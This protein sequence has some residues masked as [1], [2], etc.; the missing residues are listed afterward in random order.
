MAQKKE[1]INHA[2]RAHAL[3]SASGA[4]RWMACTPSVRIEE[5]YGHGDDE[6]SIFAKEGT[7]AHELSELKLIEVA[8]LLNPIDEDPH[9]D[10]LADVRAHELYAYEMEE[11]T[12]TY[13]DTIM[14]QMSELGSEAKLLIEERVD[15]SKYAPE[16]F[17]TGDALI[18]SPKVLVIGDLKYGKGV[19]VDATD[20]S[21]L[22]L[23]ALGALSRYH[24]DYPEIETVRLI[25][26]QPRLDHIDKYELSVKDLLK[27]GEEVVKVKASE[28]MAGTGDFKAG[29]HCRWC[30][31]APRC[32][33]LRDFSIEA[34]KADF[35]LDPEDVNSAGLTDDEMVQIFKDMSVIELWINKVQ[36]YMHKEAL[37]GKHWKGLKLVEGRS[38]RTWQDQEAVVQVLRDNLLTDQEIYS[39]KIQGI[40]AI[41]GLLGKK[42]FKEI[43][44]DLVVR[45]QG[46]ASLV[47]VSDKR[48]EMG[49][50]SARSDFDDGFNE[51]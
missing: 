48:P 43:L 37:K 27:W 8:G 40:T 14:E 26:I 47:P 44:G 36:E 28:A 42:T 6:E 45:P 39:Q 17:G 5:Q 11:H 9:S 46:K 15:F 51:I 29:S 18:L 33:A 20:N 19:Q 25:I 49:I 1:V 30:K 31:H 41:E 3:L 50:L 12:D 7:L 16:G 23:Y 38:S 22:K 24:E 4:S 32:K 35:A 10:A 34:A 2:G 13:V 21:Q